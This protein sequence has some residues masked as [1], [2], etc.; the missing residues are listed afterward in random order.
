M[1]YLH[2]V[3]FGSVSDHDYLPGRAPQKF[4]EFYNITPLQ[5]YKDFVVYPVN[6][7]LLFFHLRALFPSLRPLLLSLLLQLTETLSLTNDLRNSYR[8]LYTIEFLG[9]V[10]GGLPIR[11]VNIETDTMKRLAIEVLKSGYLVWFGADVENFSDSAMGVLDMGLYGYELAFDVGFGMGKAERLTYGESLMTVC[12][13]VSFRGRSARRAMTLSFLH[14]LS[15]PWSLR[16]SI[17]TRLVAPCVG[18]WRIHGAM[19]PDRRAIFS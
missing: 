10:A 15:T 13:R 19:P 11:H 16:A 17:S 12:V 3:L 1:R 4:N 6:I 2:V 18:A 5:F 14:I 7:P 8:R 9:N